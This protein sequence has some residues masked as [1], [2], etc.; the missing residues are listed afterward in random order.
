MRRRRK[1]DLGSLDS[2]LDTMTNV[3]GI[4]VI[5]LAVTQIGVGD[6]VERIRGFVEEVSAAELRRLEQADGDLEQ[7]V[8]QKSRELE[9]AEAQRPEVLVSLEKLRELT[10]QLEQDLQQISQTR[11]ETDELRKIAVQR[12][13][14]LGKLEEQFQEHEKQLASLNAKLDD[15]PMLE[16]DLRPTVVNLPNPRPAPRG[17]EPVELICR[18]G[19]IVPYNPGRLRQIAQ[20]FINRHAARLAAAPNRID[21]E[22]L[23]A[24][25][26]QE[27]IGNGFVRVKV[28]VAKG[29]PRL[30]VEHRE[31]AGDS[32]EE[33]PRRGSMYR[34]LL[35]QFDRRSQY[36]RFLV[37]T[38]S[39]DT[40]VAAREIADEMNVLAGWQPYGESH[41]FRIGLGLA[42]DIYCKGYE[43][44][45][46]PKSPPTPQPPKKPGAPARPPLPKD[47]ID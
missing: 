15:T 19:H 1:P 24:L 29:K 47:E 37:Y 13:E 3:V 26:E 11:T 28:E 12:A 17:F 39:F 44:Q 34:L 21:C 46:P 14:H 31:D 25:F 20:E 40:Y 41:Q 8:A 35:Q 22:R 30:V 2:L 23:T 32:T 42:K 6:A 4:L 33:I 38:D 36:L 5:L 9:D 45:P 27:D 16:A 43:P 7:S 10:E 18:H